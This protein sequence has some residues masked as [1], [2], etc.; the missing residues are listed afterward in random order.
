VLKKVA[1]TGQ[2][3]LDLRPVGTT[4]AYDL[5]M[6]TVAVSVEEIAG[7]SDP[8]LRNLWITQRYHELA[9]QLRDMGLGADATWCAFAVWA[10]KT[11]GATIRSE[12][13]PALV[14]DALSADKAVQSVLHRFNHGVERWLAE[15]LEHLDPLRAVET[16]SGQVSSYIAQGNALVFSELAPLFSALIED[17][18]SSTTRLDAALAQLSKQLPN[19]SSV[20]AAFAAYRRAI[21]SPKERAVQVLAANILAVSHEQERLQ[22]PIASALDAAVSDVLNEST[23]DDIARHV[24]TM[25]GRRVVERLLHEVGGVLDRVWQTA[26]T[27]VMLR[28]VTAD[29]ALELHRDV[30][31]LSG[32]LFPPELDVLVGTPAEAPYRQWDRTSGAGSPSG[33]RDWAQLDERMNFI[34]TLFRSRQ[35]H[36]ALFNPPFTDEQLAALGDGQRPAGPL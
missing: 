13:L 33:A 1:S 23:A 26:L 12:A 9:L 16:V 10:S 36:P 21:E 6:A 20:T 4:R 2:R 7:M 15:R 35:R 34:V 27:E 31:P 17:G 32:P 28:L 25:T 29:E 22:S 24:P 11:A 5:R 3:R 18:P 19:D 8:V 30:P 14:R